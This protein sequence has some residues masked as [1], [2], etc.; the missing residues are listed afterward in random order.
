M[1][2]N[3]PARVLVV[4]AAVGTVLTLSGCGK[5]HQPALTGQPNAES[6]TTTSAAVTSTTAAGGSGS[7]TSTTVAP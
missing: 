5:S 7:T 4:C 3:R 2:W 6:T 1:S